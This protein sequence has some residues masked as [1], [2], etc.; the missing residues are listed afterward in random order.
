MY[1]T[2]FYQI[3]D[4]E[5]N[6]V[7]KR[8]ESDQEIKKRSKDNAQLK[9]YCL[10]VWFLEFYGKIARVK[11]E[12][13]DGP[14][15]SSC[16]IIFQKMNFQKE[17]IFYVVQSK[18]NV[19]NKVDK[20]IES[21]E[22]KKALS[23]FQ[24]IL[25]GEKKDTKNQRFNENLKELRNHINKNGK[26]EF[27][28]L[29]LSLN[30]EESKENIET[31]EK[32]NPNMFVR[33]YDIERIKRDFIDVRYKKLEQQNLLERKYN[34]KEEEITITVERLGTNN[35]HI[36]ISSPFV[37]YIILVRPKM[38]YELFGQYGYSLFVENVRNPIR[39]SEINEK[40]QETLL[41][42]PAFFWYYNNG[43]TAISKLLPVLS[44]QA[45]QFSV[46]GFQVINGA[47]TVYAIYSAYSKAD[48]SERKK[49]DQEVLI[50]IRI[51]K[52]GGIDFDKNVTKFTNAQNLMNEKDFR[53]NDL[54]QI[55]L[56]NE[57]FLTRYWYEK[58]KDEFAVIPKNISVIP[59]DFILMT[60]IAFF[61]LSIYMKL[62]N[63][64]LYDILDDS[65][66]YKSLLVSY[67]VYI[68]IEN[69][70]KYQNLKAKLFFLS[71]FKL[72]MEFYLSLKYSENIDI[73]NYLNEKYEKEDKK[74]IQK[75]ILYIYD[76]FKGNPEVI[77][78][79][80]DEELTEKYVIESKELK[81]LE[82]LLTQNL[83]IE[84]I[85]SI[86]IKN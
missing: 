20:M 35:N 56:Q 72:V 4:Q 21:D 46:V 26:V 75:V 73:V 28:F 66:H 24:T 60:Y 59:N 70:S 2:D 71:L 16:D 67:L 63:L 39:N 80:S 49:M 8:Y 58:R 42:N 54:V 44:K 37:S 9:S 74:E 27:I 48:S 12:I 7:A 1:N 38:L 14:G 10:M 29:S 41:N 13:I 22:I 82:Y 6:E 32:S 5:L 36:S 53:A 34:P 11:N 50:T 65:I 55:K 76:Y 84:D 33:I 68:E 40:M 3:L 81:N 43:I 30:N 83:K 62:K 77:Q 15:D 79:F 18:W 64:G 47:Q 52:S 25:S 31:F 86:Q 23:D 85:E 69:L 57:S 45:K 17:T 51:Y 19:Q 78:Q 61:D